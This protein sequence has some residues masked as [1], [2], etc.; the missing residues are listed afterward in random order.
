MVLHTR[1]FDFLRGPL[2]LGSKYVGRP[3]HR[4][5]A[6][7]IVLMYSVG[8]KKAF[9]GESWGKVFFPF[10]TAHGQPT[11]TLVISCVERKV[12]ACSGGFYQR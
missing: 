6:L 7:G 2:K 12:K 4:P 11:N 9:L 3:N 5:L 1:S 8:P 10:T